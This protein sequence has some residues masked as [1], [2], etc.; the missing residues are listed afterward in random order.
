MS[1][2]ISALP[3]AAD[4]AT[5][6]LLA[7]VDVSDLSSAA[8]GTTKKATIAQLLALAGVAPFNVGTGLIPA[9]QGLLGNVAVPGDS[10]TQAILSAQYTSVGGI[11]TAIERTF[12]SVTDNGSGVGA[13][14]FGSAYN[15]GGGNRL[16]TSIVGADIVLDSDG[17][18]I[19]CLSTEAVGATRQGIHLFGNGRIAIGNNASSNYAEFSSTNNAAG[20]L[21]LLTEAS[22]E[23]TGNPTG[24]SFNAIR[25]WFWEADGCVKIQFPGGNILRLPDANATVS[26]GVGAHNHSAAEITSGTLVHERGGL[27]ADVSAY[28]GLVAISAGATSAVSTSLALKN[29]LSD[30]TGSGA[31]VFADAPTMTAIGTDY[32][33]YGAAP[34]TDG[35]CRFTAPAAATTQLLRLMQGGVEYDLLQINTA[36]GTVTMG[37]TGTHSLVL[38]GYDFNLGTGTGDAIFTLAGTE[39]LRVK[40]TGVQVGGGGADFGGGSLVIG[41]DNAA[42]VPT[43]N[44]T[45]GGVL[46]VQAGA[47]KYRGS[48]GTVTTLGNA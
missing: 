13:V 40:N 29:L 16:K 39:M 37:N 34:P 31:L 15:P 22:A 25:L 30:E 47:L 45:N 5:S 27:E 7:I 23:P 21:I 4:V 42:T 10:T 36:A 32:V 28:A 11:G 12:V 17:G 48:S 24:A 35:Y 33:K 18:D 9:D 8:T 14:V 44:P 46:Y 20:P 43:T 1:V 26:T 38:R 2:K 3:A 41:I 6:D 19:S